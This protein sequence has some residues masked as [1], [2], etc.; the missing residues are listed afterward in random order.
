MEILNKAIDIIAAAV[1]GWLLVSL[2]KV[3]RNTMSWKIMLSSIGV[4][5]VVGF[6]TNSIISYAAP[7]WPQDL[8]CSIAAIMG[9]ASDKLIIWYTG[10]AERVA[11]RVEESIMSAMPGDDHEGAHNNDAENPDDDK[12]NAN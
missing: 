10:L 5:A 3:V 2:P 1:L 8:R 9:A 11:D 6:V 7:S 12:K 4:A